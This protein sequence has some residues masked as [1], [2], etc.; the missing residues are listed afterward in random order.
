MN[1]KRFMGF[2]PSWRE[3]TE[4]L[5]EAIELMNR[6]FTE[7]DF[8]DFQGRY[9]QMSMVYLYVK[10]TRKIPIYYSAIGPKAAYYAG[11]YGDHL[12]TWATVKDFKEKILPNFERGARE[13]GKDPSR[14]ERVV[15]L[16][17]SVGDVEGAVRWIRR[18]I[19]GAAITELFNEPDPRVIERRAQQ[20][21]DEEIKNIYRLFP[22]PEG[23]V[24][25]AKR[26]I[27]AGANHIV[28]TD[29]TPDFQAMMR[30]YREVVIP[31]LK[32]L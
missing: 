14:M 25:E 5:C 6:L 15:L 13:A 16:G 23:M 31:E 19:A 21:S 10:P 12:L 3:R 32:A 24:E 18:V 22:S 27:E 7:E 20:M 9:F 2:W 17:G 28:F 11:R 29:F 1:E 26:F 8:F 30:A 4:R